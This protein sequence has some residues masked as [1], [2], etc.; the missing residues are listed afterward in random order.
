MFLVQICQSLKMLF[1]KNPFYK[2]LKKKKI[3]FCAYH[4]RLKDISNLVSCCLL[5]NLTNTLKN[6]KKFF[7]CAY[8]VKLKEISNLVSC[9][10][11]PYLILMFAKDNCSTLTIT[12]FFLCFSFYLLS[13]KST[14]HPI[15][16][17]I[18]ANRTR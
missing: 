2:N 9:C 13:R 8:Y 14:H 18:W 10:L 17:W 11:L 4:V 1:F 7:V 5:P 12:Y 15:N 16:I 6:K 3:V